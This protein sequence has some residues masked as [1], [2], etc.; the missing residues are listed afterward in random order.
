[1]KSQTEYEYKL[2]I[3]LQNK[4][5]LEL[6]RAWEDVRTYLKLSS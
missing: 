6:L 4:A 2:K 1:M 3:T 5:T